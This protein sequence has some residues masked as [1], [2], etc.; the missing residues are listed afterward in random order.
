MF[1]RGL[2][3][4]LQG[5]KHPNRCVCSGCGVRVCGARVRARVRERRYGAA[6]RPV[7]SIPRGG[8]SVLVRGTAPALTAN[9]HSPPQHGRAALQAG[10]SAQVALQSPQRGTTATEAHTGFGTAIAGRTLVKPHCVRMRGIQLEVVCR[11][12]VTHRT[13]LTSNAIV[14]PSFPDDPNLQYMV[15]NRVL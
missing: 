13:A 11:C 8:V 2:E 6:R 9:S 14:S 12:H 3:A 15:L 5:L 4:A 7:A 10:S 1:L